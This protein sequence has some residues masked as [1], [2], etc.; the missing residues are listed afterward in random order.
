MYG[1]TRYFGTRDWK[2][3]RRLISPCALTKW[4]RRAVEGTP[5]NFSW[6]LTW[7]Q[8]RS[9]TLLMRSASS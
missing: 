2:R 6:R 1:V 7:A 4:A 9:L 3:S 5:L 8:S